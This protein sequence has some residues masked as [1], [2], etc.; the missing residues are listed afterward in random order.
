MT[1]KPPRPVFTLLV[2]VGRA[3]GDGLPDTATGAGLLCYC[4][5]VSEEEAVNET[6]AVLR[7]ASMNPLEVEGLGTAE[8]RAAEGHVVEADELALM[9]RALTDNAVIVAQTT[10]FDD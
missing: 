5:G 9:Q 10:I 7:E 6:V 3:D 8:D 4:A 1:D 2:E